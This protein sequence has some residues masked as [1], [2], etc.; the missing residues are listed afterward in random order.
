[1]TM[2]ERIARAM[3]A[4]EIGYEMKLVSLINGISTYRLRYSDGEVFDFGSTDEVYE[5]IADRKRRT[6]VDAVLAAMR[7]PTPYVTALTIEAVNL[8]Q[9]DEGEDE[10]ILRAMVHAIETEGKT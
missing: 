2:R 1:M 10:D 4:A 7:E 5:H 8:W 6:Q 9:N 3:E